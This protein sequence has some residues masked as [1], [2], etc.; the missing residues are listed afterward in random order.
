MIFT[1]VKHLSLKVPEN[2]HVHAKKKQIKN[3]EKICINLNKNHHLQVHSSKTDTAL[4]SEESK[5][6]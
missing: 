5:S 2:L 3:E 4:E 6:N 1:A